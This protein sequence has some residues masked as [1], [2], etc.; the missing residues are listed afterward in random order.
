MAEQVDLTLSDHDESDSQQQ[1]Q[2]DASGS[3]L[4]EVEQEIKQVGSAY[5][6][7]IVVRTSK[8]VAS[9]QCARR[10]AALLL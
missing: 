1:Q 3:R 8:A 5:E 9:F 2:E 4:A 10:A 6:C 7:T